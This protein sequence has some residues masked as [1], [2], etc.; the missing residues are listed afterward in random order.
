LRNGLVTA[1]VVF[2]GCV[3]LSGCGSSSAPSPTPPAPT[4]PAPTLTSVTVSC[5]A[6]TIQYEVST[7]QCAATAHYSD[8]TGAAET[9][10]ATWQP[11]NPLAI[12]DSNGVVSPGAYIGS[13]G[14]VVITATFQGMSG[15]VTLTVKSCNVC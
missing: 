4:P 12:V 6:T 14:T 7:T 10:R 13:V 5:S 11:S 8:G 15:T 1:V 9:A 2:V 3:L